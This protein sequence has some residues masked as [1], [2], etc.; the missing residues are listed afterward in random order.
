MSLIWLR[1]KTG[2]GKDVRMY[3]QQF[4]AIYHEEEKRKLK[5]VIKEITINKI[6]FVIIMFI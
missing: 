5:R 6:A 1:I 3:V 4:E 2:F